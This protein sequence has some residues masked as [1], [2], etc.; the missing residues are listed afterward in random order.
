MNWHEWALAIRY[1]QRETNV[2]RDV[3]ITNKDQ[4]DKIYESRLDKL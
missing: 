3:H 1:T 2:R 4:E